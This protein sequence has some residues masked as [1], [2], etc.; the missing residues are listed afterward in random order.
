PNAAA[1]PWLSSSLQLLSPRVIA[2]SQGR[3]IASSPDPL[4]S[5]ERDRELPAATALQQSFPS[6]LA[7]VFAS[8]QTWTSRSSVRLMT[9]SRRT[10]EAP[11]WPPSRRGRISERHWCAR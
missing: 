1:S 6:V 2:A 11:P 9:A 4:S 3:E 7:E 10:T 8:S 5:G